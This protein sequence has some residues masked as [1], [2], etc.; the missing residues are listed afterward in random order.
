MSQ[1]LGRE[2]RRSCRTFIL[3]RWSEH[4][5]PVRPNVESSESRWGTFL[6]CSYD[7]SAPLRT[8]W[9]MLCGA[10]QNS[11]LRWHC[12]HPQPSGALFQENSVPI[13]I[14]RTLTE[15]QLSNLHSQVHPCYNQENGPLF[16]YGIIL[17]A[18]CK[19][20]KPVHPKG[21]QSWIFIGRTDA[22]AEAPILWPPDVKSRLIRKDADAGKDWRQE[23]KGATE[24]EMVG[25][26][27]WLNGHE[28]EQ[29]LGDGEGQGSLVCCS[30]WGRKESDMTEWLNKNKKA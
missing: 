21:N 26:H 23:E 3:T 11:S 18:A 5:G 20:V 10:E 16:A 22:E 2:L 4:N 14:F 15:L 24:D 29:T 30:P 1:T 6:V 8:F 19:E 27:H 7:H 28:F 9:C 12:W 17:K 25:W 13:K